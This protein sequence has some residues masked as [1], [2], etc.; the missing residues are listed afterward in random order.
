MVWT[1][2][3]SSTASFLCIPDLLTFL[4][5][6]SFVIMLSQLLL[7]ALISVGGTLAAPRPY[8][9]LPVLSDCSQAPILCPS[10]FSPQY[11][12]TVE[13][14]DVDLATGT[15]TQYVKR[16]ADVSWTNWGSQSFTTSTI[17]TSTAS[18]SKSPITT[19]S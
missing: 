19:S 13:N 18:T 14:V 12:S 17:T 3:S 1:A 10:H 9:Q 16:A 7:S 2:S 4:S 11:T 15:N 5:P 6:N 8:N